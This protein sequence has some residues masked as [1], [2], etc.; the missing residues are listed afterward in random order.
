[1]KK[2]DLCLAY[3]AA[4]SNPTIQIA[5]TTIEVIRSVNV[6]DIFYSFSLTSNSKNTNWIK[7]N[8]GYFL[9]YTI[10]KVIEIK[11][12][13]AYLNLASATNL[14]VLNSDYTDRFVNGTSLLNTTQILDIS[15][16]KNPLSFTEVMK[17]PDYY[18]GGK[19][20]GNSHFLKKLD[21]DILRVPHSKLLLKKD[22]EK[23]FK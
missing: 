15:N 1:M 3:L 18:R 9:R 5:D 12:N 19:V 11:G 6:D 8:D 20:Y 22:A 7:Q 21:A 17:M 16:L 13:S 4:L 10:W 2:I 23:I 14:N